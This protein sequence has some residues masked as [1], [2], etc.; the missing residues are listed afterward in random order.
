M[1][2]FRVVVS[3]NGKIHQLI[4]DIT[5]NRWKCSVPAD[6]FL[7]DSLYFPVG[8]LGFCGDSGSQ[9]RPRRP[10]SRL[11]RLASTGFFRRGA[12]FRTEAF[13]RIVCEFRLGWGAET[14]HRPNQHV[15]QSAERSR[16]PGSY[17]GRIQRRVRIGSRPRQIG[18]RKSSELNWFA[19]FKYIELRSRRTRSRLAC[20]HMAK[21]AFRAR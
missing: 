8:A 4:P 17:A 5:C 6:P 18:R 19:N 3:F 21:L 11:R 16:I 14:G 7:A 9:C 2:I 10:Q 1:N 12:Y 13:R 20:D 15:V